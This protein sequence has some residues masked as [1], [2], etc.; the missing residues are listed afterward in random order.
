MDIAIRA[1]NL[2]VAFDLFTYCGIIWDEEF[3]YILKR[4]LQEHANHILEN[5]EWSK[6]SR[7]NH[8]LANLCGLLVI[9]RSL[10]DTK[11]NISAIAKKKKL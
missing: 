6:V 10:P 7:G 9:L 3:S 1:A 5:L 11:H 4:S 2:L 8:Y